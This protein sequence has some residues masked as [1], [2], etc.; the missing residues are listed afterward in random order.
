MRPYP[1]IALL[2]CGMAAAP[3]RES[4]A[5]AANTRPKLI[6]GGGASEGG[7]FHAGADG[8]TWSLPKGGRIV[9]TAGAE[10]RLFGKPQ[11][12]I[13]DP[14][15]RTPTYTVMLLSGV[16][17]ADVGEG[18][19]AVL[20]SS[21]GKLNAIVKRGSMSFA[22]AEGHPS[23][24]SFDGDV[25]TATQGAY[26]S[27]PRSQALELLPDKTTTTRALLP[28]PRLAFDSRVVLAH[29]GAGSLRGLRW[30]AVSGASRYRWK[31]AGHRSSTRSRRPFLKRGWTHRWVRCPR[32]TTPCSVRAIEG[33]G[34][35]GH[36]AAPSRF[37]VIGTALPEGG[38]FDP[39]GVIR[40]GTGQSVEFS[41]VDGLEVASGNNGHFQKTGGRV[42]L[43]DESGTSVFFK[44]P[45]TL[46]VTRTEV[47]SRGVRAEL[48]FAPRNPKWPRHTL[49]VRVR[50]SAKDA[51]ALRGVA[52]KFRV[53]L[54]LEQIAVEVQ[55]RGDE[56][57]RASRLAR[58]G[59][60]GCC[61]WKCA[62]S[63]TSRS[64]AVSWRLFERKSRK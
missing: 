51:H 4:S 62:I 48:D 55:Q 14:Q 50:L 16:V 2:F 46:S 44:V 35:P 24:A 45:G 34:L 39:S 5:A 61:G 63:G 53:L 54:G 19:S 56:Y 32:V 43:A 37:T 42:T 47:A 10:L 23:V 60:P 17:H 31:S 8:A 22:S 38:Y 58:A 59:G 11:A 27:L 18:R 20:V 40:I 1:L 21:I 3:V 36:L 15:K 57:I 9:A 12:L 52:P 49:R 26:R 33:S 6:L 7:V 25:L 41:P 29:N 30:N 64:G 28:A 13:L